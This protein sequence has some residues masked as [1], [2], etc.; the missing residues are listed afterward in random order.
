MPLVGVKRQQVCSSLQDDTQIT[1]VQYCGFEIGFLF[2]GMTLL[3]TINA[4][5]V[6]MQV[7]G[8]TYVV[9]IRQ[10]RWTNYDYD[11]NPFP[12][13]S[14]Q[15]YPVP[16]SLE[17]IQPQIDLLNLNWS[18]AL[19]DAIAEQQEET[20]ALI[21]E[22]MDDLRASIIKGDEQAKATQLLLVAFEK[23]Q[24]E[25][26]KQI[27]DLIATSRSGRIGS[28]VSGIVML[29]VLGC[30]VYA[31]CQLLPLLK[32]SKTTYTPV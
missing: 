8:V 27:A 5:A 25:T 24:A 3:Y 4:T 15:L 11:S 32:S 29:C 22:N 2:P 20:R 12:Y 17:P 16:G 26:D 21:D 19:D 1:G 14:L 10:G 23:R 7:G 13:N 30:V 28:L 18:T 6:P 9:D 31:A